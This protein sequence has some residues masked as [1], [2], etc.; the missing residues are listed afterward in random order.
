MIRRSVRA[1]LAFWHTTALALVLVVFATGTYLY[2]ARVSRMRVDQSLA[3]TAQAFVEVW[4]GERG[5]GNSVAEAAR[6]A[7]Q[8]FRYRDRRVA[9]YDDDRRLVATS[10]S[11]R[12][13]AGLL[14]GR[15]GANAI[16]GLVAAARVGVPTWVT[17]GSP[18]GGVRAYA[19]RRTFEG[20]PFTI[21]V[22][23]T[24]KAEAEAM[25]SFREALLVAIPV[26]LVLSGIGGYLLARA[27][28]APVVLMSA[29]ADR[30]GA[31]SLHERLPAANAH[32]ELGR[33]GGVFNRLLGRLEEAF[34][35]Q[36]QFM[37][38]AS[39]ELRTPVAALRSAADVAL[40][41]P[42][43]ASDEYRE[44]LELVRGEGRRLS[45][46]V[47]DLFLLA[48]ADAGEQPVRPADVYLEEIL[49]E[50]ARAGR[51]LAGVRGVRF[52]APPAD[53]APF[54]GD[55]ALLQRLVMNLVDNAVKHTPPGG[56]VRLTLDHDHAVYRIAVRDTGIGVPEAARA[57]V[58][59]R[60]Y[61]SDAARTRDEHGALGGA[62]LGLSIAQWIA[63]AHAGRV[64]LAE[65]GP[66]GSLFVATLPLPAAAP[67]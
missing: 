46:I 41:R 30:I 26:A 1:R 3:E 55:P 23:R 66:G 24:L 63:E 53:E 6:H 52:D 49:A 44:A 58:F 17:I 29:R 7:T 65:T 18:E 13:G 25:E 43:R 14:A 15:A 33:L 35:Q 27:S 60:F 12:F 67:R 64:E 61:R 54:R 62:G 10:D 34:D 5:E 11:D 4:A 50:C 20:L 22:L 40:S 9:V 2:L 42:D 59:D 19:V 39:H 57:H 21:V 8:E 32:D 16:G 36:R 47:D 48:R 38:D 28:L 31:T 45:R 51:V 37:A 56:H